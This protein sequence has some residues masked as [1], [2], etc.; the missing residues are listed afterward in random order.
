VITVRKYDVLNYADYKGNSNNLV[1]GYWEYS[2]KKSSKDRIDDNSYA[3][4]QLQQL[5]KASK[6]IKSASQLKTEALT[7]FSTRITRQ[8]GTYNPE[9]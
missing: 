2:N 4:R 5:L 6:K 9:N 7:D 1:P 3:V 8:V